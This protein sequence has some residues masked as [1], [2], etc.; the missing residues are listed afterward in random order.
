MAGKGRLQ[1]DQVDKN[2]GFWA[3]PN[4]REMRVGFLDQNCVL[5]CEFACQHRGSRGGQ[6]GLERR[7]V[8]SVK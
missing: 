5:S 7:R 4:W 1:L 6:E 8:G 3:M 2:G